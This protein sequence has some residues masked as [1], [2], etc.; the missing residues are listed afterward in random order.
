MRAKQ[1]LRRVVQLLKRATGT[2]A[3]WE[4]K[5]REVDAAF[6]HQNGVDTGGTTVLTDLGLTREAIKDSIS[7][8]AADPDEF[9]QGMKSLDCDYRQFTFID[10]GAG[11]GRAMMLASEYSFRK[12]VGVEFAA[13]LVEIARQNLRRFRKSR[14]T[15]P[16]FEVVHSDAAG[17]DFP[18]EPLIVFLYNPFGN[19]TMREI[20]ARLGTSLISA[21]RDVLVLYLNPFHADAWTDNG[22]TEQRGPHFAVYRY[23]GV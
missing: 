17:Y 5:K 20:A 18:D 8:I 15:A 14:H 22:F 6:D 2:E 4:K 11:K 3:K 23:G 19:D 7:H 16:P 10:L 21:P 9:H 12:I 13:P 1:Y